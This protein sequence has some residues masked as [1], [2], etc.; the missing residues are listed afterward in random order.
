MTER[1][2]R[3]SYTYARGVVDGVS[4]ALGRGAVCGASQQFHR[5][6]PLGKKDRQYLDF[7]TVDIERAMGTTY[8][9]N[10][11][12]HEPSEGSI[13]RDCQDNADDGEELSRKH[14]G[15]D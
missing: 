13:D 2:D 1:H 3:V 9:L 14:H 4:F 10:P 15:V 5:V 7:A 8:S 12:F 6:I 11:T